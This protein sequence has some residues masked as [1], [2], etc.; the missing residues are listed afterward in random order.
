LLVSEQADSRHSFST[1]PASSRS[2][3]WYKR[4]DPLGLTVA[5][6][7][8]MDRVMCALTRNAL[9]RETG[10]PPVR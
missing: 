6:A 9:R 1:R 3:G 2:V 10:W 5:A 8:R 4:D 7:E